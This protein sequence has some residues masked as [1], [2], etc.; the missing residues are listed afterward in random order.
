MTICHAKCME[1]GIIGSGWPPIL[2]D[3]FI[4]FDSQYFLLLN[5]EALTPVSVHL[6]IT[7]PFSP[8]TLEERLLNDYA[9]ILN[10]EKYAYPMSKYKPEGLLRGTGGLRSACF[11]DE[12]TFLSPHKTNYFVISFNL[13]HTHTHTVVNK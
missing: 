6:M 2:I 12:F 4:F 9:R 11:V 8:W 1:G 10:Q 7:T 3:E 13:T 5:C